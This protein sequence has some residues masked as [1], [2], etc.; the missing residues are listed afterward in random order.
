MALVSKK[1]LAN[2]KLQSIRADNLRIFAE[3]LGID[4]RGKTSDIIKRLINVPQ[5]KI[6]EFIKRKYE[7][8]TKERQVIISEFGEL[9]VNF[10]TKLQVM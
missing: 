8:L 6:D 5:N 3:S 10:I 9:K 7:D 4:S 1:E 2:L